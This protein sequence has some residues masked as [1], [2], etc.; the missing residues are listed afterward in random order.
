M[1]LEHFRMSIHKLL[2]KDIDIVPE[3]DH[4][5]ILDSKSD[6]CMDKNGKDTNK[7]SHI[8]IRVHFVRNGKE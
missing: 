1:A 4:L 5:I 3:E 2:N 6:V 8:S 7:T